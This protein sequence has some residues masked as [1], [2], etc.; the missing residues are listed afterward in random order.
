V[1]IWDV[2]S[3]C[4]FSKRHLTKRKA[5]YREANYPFSVEKLDWMKIK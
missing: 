2:T 4:K 1:A 3:T 5:F